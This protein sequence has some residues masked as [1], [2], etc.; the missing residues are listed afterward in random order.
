MFHATPQRRNVMFLKLSSII[1]F[2]CRCVVAPLRETQF[3]SRHAATTPR[4]VFKN[5]H[6]SLYFFV[7]AP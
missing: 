6:Q 7:V 1:V 3:F 2:F 5:F 4:D